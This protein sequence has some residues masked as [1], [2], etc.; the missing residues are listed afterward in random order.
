LPA[1]KI[2][3]IPRDFHWED[4]QWVNDP[5][6]IKRKYQIGPVDPLVLFVGKLSHDYGT[7]ILAEAIPDLIENHPQLRFLLVGEGELMWPIR[8]KAHYLLYEHAV[9]L[10][11][12]K[13]GRDLNELF[14]AADM[15]VIPNRKI[16]SPYQVFAAWSAKKPVI[17]TVAGSCNLIRHLENGILVYDNPNSIGWGIERILFDWDRGYEIARNG[18]REVE[19]NYTWDA[20][21]QKLAHIYQ[22]D[23]HGTQKLR[24]KG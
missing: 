19:Q 15:V 17:A 12:H 11:G 2:S 20:M 6:E 8:I 4:F 18:L 14:Q 13:E 21:S 24:R 1:E 16:L 22:F 10:V 23:H 7:D 5:G 3:V 9:R